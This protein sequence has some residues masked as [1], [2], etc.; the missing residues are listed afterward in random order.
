M[1]KP[2]L[3]CIFPRCATIFFLIFL[4]GDGLRRSR[5]FLLLILAKSTLHGDRHQTQHNKALGVLARTCPRQLLRYF[6]VKGPHRY[7]YRNLHLSLNTQ[8]SAFVWVSDRKLPVLKP[9]Y[10]YITYLFIL[11]NFFVSFYITVVLLPTMPSPS[12]DNLI[13]ASPSTRIV[14]HSSITTAPS[15]L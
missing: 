4:D 14:C 3:L 15:D 9:L 8:A 5:S 13:S 11:S 1:A 7:A 12:L 10:Y 2:V 6:E